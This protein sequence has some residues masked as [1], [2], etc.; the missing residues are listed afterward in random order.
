[1]RVGVD[2]VQVAHVVEFALDSGYNHID[3]ALIYSKFKPN[4]SV[5]E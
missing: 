1:M 4:S 5:P 2:L 3:A